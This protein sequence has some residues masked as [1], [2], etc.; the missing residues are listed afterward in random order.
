MINISTLLTMQ[1]RIFG[2]CPNCHDFF[3]LSDC[4][5]FSKKKPLLDW[6]DKIDRE[7]D[8][9][10][11]LAEKIKEQEDAI[12][13]KGREKGRRIADRTIKKIDP[14]FYPRKLNP[15]DAKVIFHPIDY[16]IFNGMK[17][18][19]PMENIILLDREVRMREHKK[20]QRSIQKVINHDRYEWLT[21]KVEDDGKVCTQ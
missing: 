13:E 5:I 8:Q 14:I 20:I 3:R 7:H 1:R 17:S 16:I 9:L 21:I 10:D 15:D 12:R 6:K 2:I 19:E 11:S 4:K 18:K